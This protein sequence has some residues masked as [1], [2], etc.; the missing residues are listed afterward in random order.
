MTLESRIGL[1]IG[2]LFERFEASEEEERSWALCC[3][4]VDAK[5]ER[6]E[7]RELEKL[8][9]RSWEARDAIILAPCFW[10]RSMMLLAL[11]DEERL[12]GRHWEAE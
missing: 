7:V 4:V 9:R 10:E 1:L 5:L 2:E 12:T 8:S 3:E 11:S 6:V